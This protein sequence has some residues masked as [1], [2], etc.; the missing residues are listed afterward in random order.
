MTAITID[1]DTFFERPG[2]TPEHQ[3]NGPCDDDDIPI[4]IDPAL[5]WS[6]F[7]TDMDGEQV[8]RSGFFKAACGYLTATIP[9]PAGEEYVVPCVSE[10]EPDDVQDHFLVVHRCE[11]GSYELGGPFSSYTKACDSQKQTPTRTPSSL[12]SPHGARLA[13]Q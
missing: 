9:V 6:G 3:E 1:E 5:V 12:R 10:R 7:D 11:D 13:V 4:G 8:I 2:V